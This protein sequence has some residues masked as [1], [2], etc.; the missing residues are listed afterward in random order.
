MKKFLGSFSLPPLRSE[1]RLWSNGP[2]KRA[3]LVKWVR[4]FPGFWFPVSNITKSYY[5][6]L[7]KLAAAKAYHDAARADEKRER[8]LV[9][10]YI[11]L[12]GVNVQG[13]VVRDVKGVLT[14]SNTNGVFDFELK[15]GGDAVT[16]AEQKGKVVK[17]T[18]AN[19][20]IVAERPRQNNG[21]KG[22]QNNQQNQNQH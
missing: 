5:K 9:N 12:H 13:T 4:V 6:T 18:F 17:E 3:V 7:D 2:T 15:E 21:Q 10:A 11:K 19:L 1:I 20:P 16:A 14:L 8:D 22:G